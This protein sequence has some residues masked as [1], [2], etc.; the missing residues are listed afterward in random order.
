[1]RNGTPS[2][3]TLTFKKKHVTTGFVSDVAVDLKR[4]GSM[5]RETSLE[6]VVQ[7]RIH[8]KLA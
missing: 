1:M 2:K 6:V 3:S 4:M 8:D 5:N 7:R